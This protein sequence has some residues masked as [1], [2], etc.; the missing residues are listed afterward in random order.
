MQKHEVIG[1]RKCYEY[2]DEK[3]INVQVHTNDMNMG[4]LGMTKRETRSEPS[5]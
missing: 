5:T 3:D 1:T 4:V 2:L